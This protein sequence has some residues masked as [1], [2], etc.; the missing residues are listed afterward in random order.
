MENQELIDI[1]E[2]FDRLY[3]AIKKFWKIMVIVSFV[4]GFGIVMKT[5]LSYH[6]TYTSSMT[7]IISQKDQNILVN[8]EESEKINQSFQKALLSPSM[9]KIICEDLNQPTIPASLS[10]NLI[11]ETNLLS[12][13][14]TSNNAQDAYDV[15]QSIEKNYG[16]ITKLMNDA[17]MILIQEAQLPTSANMKPQYFRQGIK[18]FMIG[19]FLSFIVV[20]GYALTRRTIIKEQQIKDKFHLKSL[21][22]IPEITIKK[23]N[24]RLTKQLLVTNNHIPSSFK[25]SF[26]TL[27]MAIQSKKDCQVLMCTSTLPNEGKSTINS[28]IALMLAQANKKV[29]SIDLD[30]RNPSLYNIFKIEH[31]KYQIG[32]YLEGTCKIEDC[33]CSSEIDKN[34]D[35]IVGFKSYEHSIEMLSNGKLA[36]CIQELRKHYDYIIV[37]V[38][39]ILVM[40]DALVVLKHCDETILVI[41]QDFAK[42]Y[43]IIDGLDELYEIDRNI[44]GCVLNSVQ[45]SIF[46]ED[47]RGYGYGYGYGK[48]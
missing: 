19:A 43:E 3:K 13:S 2:Y 18:G 10:V 4:C 14:A 34:L 15:I 28:N 16:Q 24:H 48:K 20:L 17:N 27:L 22:S 46:D 1:T 8:T 42:T 31:T 21:G 32:D 6:P 38:P 7:I 30:L 26:R 9:S 44:M 41:K 23:G 5:F 33:I 35:I 39:P 47:A 36:Q 40:Q 45:K 37:D 11:P 29:I 25:E 12:I